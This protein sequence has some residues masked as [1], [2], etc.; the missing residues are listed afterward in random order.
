[1]V[2]NPYPGINAHVNSMLQTPGTP[3]QP[4]L[5]HSFHSDHITF[6]TAAINSRI[7]PHYVAMSEQ[8][9]QTRGRDYFG[10]VEIFNPEPDVTVFQR[11]DRGEK[12]R[13]GTLSPTTRAPLAEVLEIVPQPFAVLIRE[14]MKQGRLGRVVA[15][16]ELLSPSNKP[17]GSH[18][19]AYRAKRI[20][21]IETGIPLIE[22]DY[23]HELPSPFTQLP[24]YPNEERSYPYHV[25]ISDPRPDWGTREIQAFSFYV[26]QPV[27]SFP[28]PLDRD[29]IVAI[30]LNVVYQETLGA[31]AWLDLID[32]AQLPERFETYSADDQAFIRE[33]MQTASD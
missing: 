23:L 26:S 13:P 17:K 29:E 28:L 14:T 33:V 30:D 3:E 16:I 25:L 6:L 31:G 12:H 8:S 15:R 4:A 21:V 5:W 9:I 32:Y 24:L 10:E 1:V 2:T 27:T 11:V 22:I 18:Y 7:R 20:S 19:Q